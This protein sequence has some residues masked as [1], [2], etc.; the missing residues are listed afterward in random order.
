MHARDAERRAACMNATFAHGP[1]VHARATLGTGSGEA[2]RR[3][4][5]LNSCAKARA[6]IRFFST[7][8]R[9][10]PL[11][12]AHGCGPSSGATCFAAAR[13]RWREQRSGARTDGMRTTPSRSF[14][15]ASLTLTL[16]LALSA[17]HARAEEPRPRG[18]GPRKQPLYFQAL[19]ALD[20]IKVLPRAVI[21]SAGKQAYEL[22]AGKPVLVKL[23]AI[24]FVIFPFEPSKSK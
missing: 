7:Q 4:S 5:D 24:D 19:F 17:S 21:G 16:L 10:R 22:R 12:C 15:P 13:D 6:P 23:P 9:D 18:R 14:A 1:F 11:F 2:A 3:L 8:L 20:R